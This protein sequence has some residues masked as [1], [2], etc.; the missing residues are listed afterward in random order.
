MCDPDACV[1]L[2][3]YMLEWSPNLH[4]PRR[5]RKFNVAQSADV[6]DCVAGGKSSSVGF[7][8]A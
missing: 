1:F 2:L 8:V 6:C 5:V 7:E 4:S 3:E